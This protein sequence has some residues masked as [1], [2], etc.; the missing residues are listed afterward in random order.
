[1]EIINKK[2]EEITI[3]RMINLKSYIRFQDKIRL[4]ISAGACKEFGI[5]KD[6]K[7]NLINDDNEWL[8]YFDN[9]NDGF[10]LF[11]R[12]NRGDLNTNNASLIHLFINRTKCGLPCK[13]PLQLTKSKYEGHHLIKIEINKPLE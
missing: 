2:H 10:E 13:F 6:L 3:N 12:K 1:M 7:L 8:I 5:T 9:S 4:Y 11:S